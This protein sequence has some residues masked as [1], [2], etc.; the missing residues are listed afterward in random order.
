M[1]SAITNQGKMRFKVFD[2]TMNADI[3]IDFRQRLIK[4]SCRKVYLIFDFGTGMMVIE[5]LQQLNG[6]FIRL[7]SE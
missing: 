2:G 5:S 1:I 7:T 3:L 4:S 6:G